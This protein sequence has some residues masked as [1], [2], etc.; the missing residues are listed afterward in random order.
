VSVSL[1]S[2]L[3]KRAKPR[4]DL[5]APQKRAA[6]ADPED[7]TMDAATQAAFDTLRTALADLEAAISTRVSGFAGPG[8][9]E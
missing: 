7:D 9:R 3:A 5:I 2:L 8:D 1:P 4:A 6:E